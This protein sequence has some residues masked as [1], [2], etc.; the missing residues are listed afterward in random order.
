MKPYER[1][2]RMKQKAGVCLAHENAK[3]RNAYRCFVSERFVI[4]VA[5]AIRQ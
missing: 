1:K 2:A 3:V 5:F 4:C